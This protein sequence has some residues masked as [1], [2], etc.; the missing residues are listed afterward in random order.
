[1]SQITRREALN[2]IYQA[3]IGAGASG[4]LSFED[5][6]AAQN[7]KI[8]QPTIIW[9][10]GTSCS[11]CSCSFLNIE[12]VPVI[13]LITEFMD[14]VYHPDLSLATGNDALKIINELINSN[15]QYIFVFEGAIPVKLPHTCLMGGVP[16][17]EWVNR[18]ASKAA[19]CIAAGTC[20]AFGGVAKMK[21]TI[22]GNM[23]LG[24][25]MDYKSIDI[26]LVN[27]PN[28]PLKPEHITY[29]LLYYIKKKALPELDQFNRP[30]HQFLKTVHDRCVYYR[31]F[32]ED[33]FAEFIGDAGCLFRLG[34]QGPVTH[35]DCMKIGHNNNTNICIRAGHPCIGCADSEF[36]RK[37][38][39]HQYNDKRSLA[40]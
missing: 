6:L 27:L 30:I 1:M 29:I 22:T 32:Q 20:A 15:R 37:I 38:M 5:V 11:G 33:N 4:F 28:C 34:C 40:R 12:D 3:I 19:L 31:D 35:N 39:Y 26:P 10:H 17:M 14:L 13:E 21:G 18:L 2:K 25:Y 7:N 36:P 23:S 24:E 9:L 8:N 16:M